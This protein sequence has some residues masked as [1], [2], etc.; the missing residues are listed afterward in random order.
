ML[1]CIIK[2]EEK[3]LEYLL[4][5]QGEL[6]N[7]TELLNKFIKDKYKKFGSLE[8]QSVDYDKK[9]KDIVKEN[10]KLRDFKRQDQE[11]FINNLSISELNFFVSFQKNPGESNASYAKWMNNIAFDFIGAIITN[12]EDAPIDLGAVNSTTQSLPM[13]LAMDIA[14]AQYYE[15]FKNSLI[16][17]LGSLNVIGNPQQLFREITAGVKD[18]VDKPLDRNEMDDGIMPL[19]VGTGLIKGTGSLVTHTVGGAFGSVNRITKTFA[20]GISTI[21]IDK[22]YNEK[23]VK[24]RFEKTNGLIGN[25]N[26]SM[27]QLGIGVLEG[28]KGVFLKPIE[29]GKKDGASGVL[30][31]AYMGVTG[32]VVKPV[33]GVLDAAST[34]TGGISKATKMESEIPNE[35]RL[36]PPRAFYGPRRAIR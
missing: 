6:T 12:I 17:I 31:G 32:L 33:A 34:L 4:D 9:L 20:D 16:K 28:V 23:R 5:M 3:M 22:D 24:M 8:D 36:R 10:W 7:D 27:K 14:K 18:F 30:K 11:N 19:S 1:P 25:L 21:H 26:K 15:D 29:Y 13:S 35:D 2:V